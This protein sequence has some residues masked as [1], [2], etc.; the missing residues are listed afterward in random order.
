MPKVKSYTWQKNKTGGAYKVR[1]KKNKAE[2]FNN[3]VV[4]STR[5]LV[6]LPIYKLSQLPPVPRH[7]WPS[8]QPI[9]PLNQPSAVPVT[10][11]EAIRDPT[12][13]E[14]RDTESYESDS[15]S[16]QEEEPL[17]EEEEEPL[18]ADDG[19]FSPD[20]M[21]ADEIELAEVRTF[22]MDGNGERKTC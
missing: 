11:C 2:I 18:A 6:L 1:V 22:E 16:E 8:V 17:A 5:P 19:D 4:P 12:P 7:P 10:R 21:D 9:V 3:A 14:D 15:G 20:E 13:V